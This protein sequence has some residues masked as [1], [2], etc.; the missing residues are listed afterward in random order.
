[1]NTLWKWVNTVRQRGQM[2]K[3]LTYVCRGLDDHHPSVGWTSVGNYKWLL[4]GTSTIYWADVLSDIRNDQ[5]L[6]PRR[7]VIWNRLRVLVLGVVA[8]RSLIVSCVLSSPESSCIQS[9]L[10]KAMI[11]SDP[12]EESRRLRW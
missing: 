10:D 5:S 4:L 7:A 8:V 11:S 6:I 2:V 9:S 3:W 1:M 12:A